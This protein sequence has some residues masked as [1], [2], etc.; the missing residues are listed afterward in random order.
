[1]TIDNLVIALYPELPPEQL[2]K[3]RR[4]LIKE[5]MKIFG[6]SQPAVWKWLKAGEIPP[7]RAI[8]LVKYY[9]LDAE[10]LLR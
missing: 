6:I 5:I 3:Q 8:E 9:K 7:A 4:E 2:C 1:M 10:E